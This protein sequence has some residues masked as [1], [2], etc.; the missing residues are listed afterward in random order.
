MVYA[1]RT[2]T[3]EETN[4]LI[5]TLNEGISSTKENNKIEILLQN[6]TNKELEI[7]GIIGI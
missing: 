2:L 3:F 1:K 6:L 7:L 5:I 4:Q